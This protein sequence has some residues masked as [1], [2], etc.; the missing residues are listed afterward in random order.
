LERATWPRPRA[1]ESRGQDA[2]DD[3]EKQMHIY[4]R[5]ALALLSIVAV[6]GSTGTMASTAL[7]GSTILRSSVLPSVPT[8]PILHGVEAGSAPW[9]LKSGAIRLRSDGELKVRVAGLIIPELGT[10]GPVTSIDAS[11]YCG[12][13]AAAAVTT[14]TTPLSLKGNGLLETTVTLPSSCIT[15]VVLINPLGITSIYI[16]TSGFGSN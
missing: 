1:S 13:E 12:N 10:P 7:A 9:I 5:A 15:P 3:K 16:A 11:L 8:D 14:G 6:A 4:R 2:I